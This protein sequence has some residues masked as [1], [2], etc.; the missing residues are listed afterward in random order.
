MAKAWYAPHL[1]SAL[2]GNA[3]LLQKIIKGLDYW[4]DHDYTDLKC[5]RGV[6]K[7]ETPGSLPS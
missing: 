3:V 1:E 4:F 5:P 2:H 6:C 7:C